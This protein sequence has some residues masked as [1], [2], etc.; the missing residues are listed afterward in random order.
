MHSGRLGMR[1]PGSVRKGRLASTGLCSPTLACEELWH[2][3]CNRVSAEGE[4]KGAE[5]A[6]INS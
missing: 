5:N 6:G 2:N 4:K 1:D 3:P